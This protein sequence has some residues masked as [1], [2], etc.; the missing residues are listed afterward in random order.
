MLDLLDLAATLLVMNGRL[1]YFLPVAV[2]EYTEHDIPRHDC[3]KLISNCRRSIR[4]EIS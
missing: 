2:E 3:L 4:L 1:V